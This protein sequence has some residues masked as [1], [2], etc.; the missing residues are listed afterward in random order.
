M[1][2]G[3]HYVLYLL[4]ELCRRVL[5]GRFTDRAIANGR[6]PGRPEETDRLQDNSPGRAGKMK[7]VRAMPSMVNVSGAGQSIAVLTSGGDAQGLPNIEQLIRG[8]FVVGHIVQDCTS[9]NSTSKTTRPPEIVVQ[10]C[11]CFCTLCSL[12][13]ANTFMFNS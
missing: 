7:S 13:L 1:I 12:L 5:P 10:K 2:A 8:C 4:S 9:F 11:T 6:N 3:L